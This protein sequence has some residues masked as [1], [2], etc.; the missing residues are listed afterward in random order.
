MHG[1]YPSYDDQPFLRTPSEPSG[2]E[3]TNRYLLPM[4]LGRPAASAPFPITVA[5]SVPAAVPPG[6]AF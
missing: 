1:R 3:N 6:M 5:T 2:R 4:T